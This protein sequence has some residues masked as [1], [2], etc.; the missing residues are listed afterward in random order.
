MVINA[1]TQ[2]VDPLEVVRERKS[3]IFT[4]KIVDDFVYSGR[5]F[6]EEGVINK[7]EKFIKLELKEQFS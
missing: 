7:F 5:N 6:E 4:V 3:R 2:T 1:M